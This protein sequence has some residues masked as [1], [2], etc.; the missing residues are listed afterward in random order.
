M[1]WPRQ[2]GLVAC[3]RGEARSRYALR[4]NTHSTRAFSSLRYAEQLASSDC[5]CGANGSISFAAE[6]STGRGAADRDCCS[7]FR[8]AHAYSLRKNPRGTAPGT[9]HEQQVGIERLST[10]PLATKCGHVDGTAPFFAGVQSIPEACPSNQ[11][12]AY[13]GSA[14]AA[15]GDFA[16]N[17]CGDWRSQPHR[18]VH[19]YT[20]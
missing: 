12:Y 4:K 13:H 5:A 17:N 3:R 9:R 1:R 20:P 8:R 16:W 6:P 18:T 11:R 14:R 19:R 2:S 10:A 15:C 7:K